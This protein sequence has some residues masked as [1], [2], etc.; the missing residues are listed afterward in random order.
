MDDKDRESIHCFFTDGSRVTAYLRAFASGEDSVTFGRVLTLEHGKGIG[1]ELVQN[2]IE[3]VKARL[4]CKKI[5]VHSQKQA[6]DFY[7]KLGFEA[8]SG[9]YM[10][11]GVIHVTME[12]CV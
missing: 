5:C 8:V 6:M 2:S 9:E 4:N 11:A 10:E 3:E 12:K 1:T 7:K